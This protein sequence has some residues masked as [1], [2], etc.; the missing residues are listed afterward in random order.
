MNLLRYWLDFLDLVFP[1]CCEACAKA[2]VG[3]EQLICT[4]CRM[5]LPRVAANSTLGLAMQQKF[6][7]I[8]EVKGVFPYLAFSKKGKVQALLHALK[9][10][11]RQEVGTFLGTLFGRELLEHSLLPVADLIVSVPLHPRRKKER[12]FNQSDAFAQGLS[13]V[14]GI[15]WS[16]TALVRT[17]YTR[18]QTGK[19]RLERYENMS[20]VFEVRNVEAVAGKSIIIVDDVLTTGA[21]LEACI[22]PLR[23]L[24][25]TVYILT[26]AAAQN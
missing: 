7:G 2:L 4:S 11:G 23:E 12:G 9:Y 24:S 25:C 26:I 5:T 18:T 3:S 14:S 22:E 15:P 6:A 8:P 10:R 21:T 19:S 17:R 1:R 20:G 13:A 16:G